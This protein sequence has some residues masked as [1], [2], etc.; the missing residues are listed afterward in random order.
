[1]KLASYARNGANEIRIGIVVDDSII[2]IRDAGVILELAVPREMLQLIE[3][4]I[5]YRPNLLAI[6]EPKVSAKLKRAGAI[7]DLGSIRLLAPI[8]QPRKNLVCMALNYSE[9]AKETAGIRNRDANAPTVPVLFTKATTT[10]NGPYGDIVIDAAVSTQIDWEVELAV[11]I[12]S[13]GKNISK[14]DALTYVFG[15][16]VIND[17]TARDLQSRHKQ[18]FKGKSLDGYGPMGP[19]IVTADEIRDPH[20][21]P[22]RLRVNGETKQDS[23]TSEMVFNI[24]EIIET[25]SLGITIEPGDIIATGTPNGVGF[26]RNP[27]QFLKAG[28]MMESEIEGIGFMRNHVVGV[29]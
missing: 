25:L 5:Q 16:T 26:S 20:N 11:I 14:G 15:Y 4:Y 6:A 24:A 13:K 18:F 23:N 28:D 8:P 2:D 22:L 9:H 1:M 10:V 12:G 7:E 17:V 19:W 21:L 29:D 3:E 27:P